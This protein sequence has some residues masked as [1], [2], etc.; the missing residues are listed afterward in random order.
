ML[1]T[2]ALNEVAS[3]AVMMN[4]V[5]DLVFSIWYDALSFFICRAS[6]SKSVEGTGAVIMAWYILT[7]FHFGRSHAHL[8]EDFAAA[9]WASH[10]LFDIVICYFLVAVETFVFDHGAILPSLLVIPLKARQ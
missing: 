5:F 10:S 2:V 7:R 8:E 1:C 6:C 3:L 4:F 9:V